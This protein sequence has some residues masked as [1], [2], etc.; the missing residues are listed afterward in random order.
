MFVKVDK[1]AKD[2]MEAARRSYRACIAIIRTVYNCR[3]AAAD[4]P[5]RVIECIQVA[6]DDSPQLGSADSS[7]WYIESATMDGEKETVRA[8]QAVR[9]LYFAYKILLI[10]CSLRPL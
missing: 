8:T 4:T 10:R 1:S 3:S 7:V 9:H 2:G 5:P 6:D